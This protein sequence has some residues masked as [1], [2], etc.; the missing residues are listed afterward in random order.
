[1]I[2]YI[3]VRLLQAIPTVVLASIFVFL[4]I[5]LVPGDPALILA[6]PDPTPEV[7]AAI[8]QKMGLDQSLPVQYLTWAGNALHG[9]LGV[10]YIN[11]YPTWEL[12]MLRAPASFELLVAG[13]TLSLLVALP[14]GILASL[15]QHSR[16]DM[17]ISIYTSV[18]LGIPNFW[19]GILLILLFSL[20]L[21][22]LPPGGRVPLLEDPGRGWKYLVMPVVALAIAQAAILTRF[23]RVSML[24]VLH[25]DYIR[26]ARAKGLQER[27]ILVRH[28]LRNALVP[29]VTV[30]GIQI[31]RLLGGTVII[32]TVFAWPGLGRMLINAI[33]TRDY[34]VVQGGLLLL[35][36]AFILVNLITDII[37]AFLDPRIRL[38]KDSGA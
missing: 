24:E 23:V 4:L 18:A 12:V 7:V 13:F 1:M 16:I 37:Y 6:G 2:R 15:R 17:G 32:E 35:V 14:L 10:S 34:A 36:M 29:I 9:D 8:R 20:G 31:G 21:G 38:A 11:Q 30:A 25:D 26:T 28:A 22:W 5:H 27:V 33:A 3:I 19:L